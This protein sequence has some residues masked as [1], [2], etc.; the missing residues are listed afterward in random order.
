M[1]FFLAKMRFEKKIEMHGIEL[2]D[3]ELLC[4]KPVKEDLLKGVEG[5]MRDYI[6]S[7]VTIS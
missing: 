4:P 3:D 6:R 1:D 7:S 2:D 5:M